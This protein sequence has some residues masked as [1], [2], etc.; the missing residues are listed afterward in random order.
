MR[1]VNP[2][3]FITALAASVLLAGTV[4]CSETPAGGGGEEANIVVTS[5][6]IGDWAVSLLEDT[7]NVTVLIPSGSDP[8]E[9]QPSTADIQKLH[10]ADLVFAVGLGFEEA[11]EPQ[12]ESAE[13]DGV[14]VLRLAEHAQPLSQEELYGDGGTTPDP[15]VWQDPTRVQLMVKHM[16]EE[17]ETLPRIQTE[18]LDAN[19]AAYLH[20]LEELD[21]E[22]EQSFAQLE[23]PQR[24]IV[25]QHRS[26][27]YLTH[28][29][30]LV[31]MG[32]I[33]PGVST[34]SEANASDLQRTVSLLQEHGIH[35]I[36]TDMS[37]ADSLADTVAEELKGEV[38]LVP[39]FT[40]SL[41]PSGGEADTYV[42]MMRWNASQMVEA[43][44]K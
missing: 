35:T 4:S 14:S 41:A 5:G 44:S 12:L 21:E 1:F 40:E 38:E 24:N 22:L 37:H 20:E 11:L 25:T 10:T 27:G 33:V 7:E 3:L 26:L 6:I 34:L 43:L 17:L 39:L 8:H 42:K 31:V 36:F 2:R 19:T 18:Q 13:S 30:E 23:G 9:Y 15:H 28:R 16:A 29:Y 32:Q